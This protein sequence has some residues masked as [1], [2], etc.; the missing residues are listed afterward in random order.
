MFAILN[1]PLTMDRS[2]PDQAEGQCLCVSVC[3]HVYVVGVYL[4][5]FCKRSIPHRDDSAESAFVYNTDANMFTCWRAK[6]QALNWLSCLFVKLLYWASFAE[7]EGSILKH[8]TKPEAFQRTAVRVKYSTDF[9][10]TPLAI[11]SVWT[12][13]NLFCH[14]CCFSAIAQ[15]DI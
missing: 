9:L 1:A 10:P 13:S 5:T 14:C 8:L 2:E 7:H 12:H 6:I 4:F 15:C 11:D 3:V